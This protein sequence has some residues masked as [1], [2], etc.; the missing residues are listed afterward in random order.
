M[1]EIFSFAM[2]RVRSTPRDSSSARRLDRGN[3]NGATAA[4]RDHCKQSLVRVPKKLQEGFNR[5][6]G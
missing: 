6:I 1:R 5:L 4:F 2:E 3:L